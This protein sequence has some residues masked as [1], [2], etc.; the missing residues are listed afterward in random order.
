MYDTDKLMNKGAEIGMLSPRA[1][2][3]QAPSG[4]V[5]KAD[6]EGQELLVHP[7]DVVAMLKAGFKDIGLAAKSSEGDVLRKRAFVGQDDPLRKA[8]RSLKIHH[9]L[10]ERPGSVDVAI[11]AHDGD[12]QI[13][14]HIAKRGSIGLGGVPDPDRKRELG[15]IE[16]Q[17]DSGPYAGPHRLRVAHD[18]PNREMNLHGA[19][20]SLGNIDPA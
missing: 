13:S 11:P 20:I 14:H 12:R 3:F 5:Y 18:S 15:E 7:S 1:G 4:K 8:A 10:F 16:I 2:S 9:Q 6:Y 19:R 17:I